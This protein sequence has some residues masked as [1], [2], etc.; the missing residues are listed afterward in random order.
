MRLLFITDLLSLVDVV[1]GSRLLEEKISTEER[2]PIANLASRTARDVT[3]AIFVTLLQVAVSHFYRKRVRC[4]DI[5]G[6]EVYTE[7]FTL[8]DYHT[9]TQGGNPHSRFLVCIWGGGGGVFLYAA[10]LVMI[11]SRR[12]ASAATLWHTGLATKK[13]GVRVIL[14]NRSV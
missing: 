9:A 3:V 8:F 6:R 2:T 4:R 13:D 11:G 7:D 1:E 12:L 5:G 10:Y 14:F